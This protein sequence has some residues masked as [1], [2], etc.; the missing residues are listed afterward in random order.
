MPGAEQQPPPARVQP[1]ARNLRACG[2][3][4]LQRQKPGRGREG[5]YRGALSGRCQRLSC[6]QRDIALAA[7]PQASMPPMRPLV[8]NPLFASLTSLPGVG[9]KLE[10]LYAQLLDREAPR[11]VDLLFHLPSG[12]IDRRARPKLNEV[13]PGQVV[14]VAVHGRG[15]SP[16]AAATVRARPIA[17]SPAT[18]PATLT[19]TYFNARQDYLEKLLPVGEMRYVSG[20]AEVLRRHVADGASRPRGGR[21]RLCRPAAGRAGLSAHRR[22]GA[23]QCAARDG[24]RARASCPHLPEWQDEAWVVARALPAFADALRH[25]HR[26]HEPHDVA[27]ESLAWTRLAYDELLAGQLALALV[28]AHMR[29]QAGR[30]TSSEG[31]MRAQSPQGAALRAHAFAAAGG[32]RHHRPTSPARSACCGCCKATSAPARRWWRSVAAAAVIE[33]G[34]QAAFMAPTEILAR[35]H[36]KTIA[37]L[38]EA[39]GIRVAIL[40]GRERGRARKEILD[41]SRARRYRSHRSAR[42]RCSRRT[43]PSTISRSPWSTSSTASA[44]ISASR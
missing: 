12:A 14:T 27:P 36:L 23:R 13:L 26:P 3:C 4:L 8:L 30:G 19:L 29:R 5:L 35:Q 6:A 20:T 42:M 37:P 33:A 21:E 15:A 25:L 2:H 7:R 17:S 43:S 31:H 32:R 38:A 11:V 44:C 18:T 1:F 28:R 10:K 16:A 39:A 9:P 34:R 22:A 40:T 41:R 24:W